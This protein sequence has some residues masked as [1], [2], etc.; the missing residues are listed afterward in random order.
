MNERVERSLAGS[1]CV[2]PDEERLKVVCGGL[3]RR[4]TRLEDALST[5]TDQR[6]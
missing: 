5:G 1:E 4:V 3:D 2:E 6:E